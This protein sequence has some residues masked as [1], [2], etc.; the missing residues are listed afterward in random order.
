MKHLDCKS[1]GE[2]EQ[3]NEDLCLESI[4]SSTSSPVP[5]VQRTRNRK[6]SPGAL[7]DDPEARHQGTRL[8]S[9]T[10]SHLPLAARLGNPEQYAPRVTAAALANAL[11]TVFY[12]L[13]IVGAVLSIL[14]GPS[15]CFPP[16]PRMHLLKLGLQHSGTSATRSSASSQSASRRV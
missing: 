4:E 6:H 15:P 12:T 14:A 3:D 16:P 7:K 9:L 2:E 13:S 5:L 1:G 8:N 11:P 10:S